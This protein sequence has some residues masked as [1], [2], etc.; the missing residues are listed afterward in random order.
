MAKPPLVKPNCEW[1]WTLPKGGTK[2][3]KP[4]TLP[5]IIEEINTAL[6]LFTKHVGLQGGAVESVKF[7][8]ATE[9]GGRAVRIRWRVVHRRLIKALTR[10]DDRF[11]RLGPLRNYD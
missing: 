7:I 1:L 8:R 6:R 4:G 3:H 2:G 9:A 10:R 11:H 5:N